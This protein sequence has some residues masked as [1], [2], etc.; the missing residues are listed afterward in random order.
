LAGPTEPLEP[1][2]HHGA[3]LHVEDAGRA[4]LAA[5]QAPAGLYN[6]VADGERVSNERFKRTTGWRP[7]HRSSIAVL[8]ERDS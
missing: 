5:L 3:T 8:H 2:P 6:V 4:M 7:L 1:N